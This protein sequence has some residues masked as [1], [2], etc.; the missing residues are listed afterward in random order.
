MLGWLPAPPFSAIIFST[1]ARRSGGIFARTSGGIMLPF[2]VV[3]IS[4]A[5]GLAANVCAD[6]TIGSASA[7]H[8]SANEPPRVFKNAF[9]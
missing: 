2:I 4:H 8:A 7:V 1:I 9:M 3:V 5:P 6:A